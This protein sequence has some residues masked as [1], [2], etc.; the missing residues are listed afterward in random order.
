NQDGVFGAQ[1][2]GAGMGGCAMIL[3]DKKKRDTIKN[4]IN[5]NYVKYFKKKCSIS[6]CQPVNGL[7]IYSSI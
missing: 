2:S 5:D 4:L 6:F 7:S 3:V 1:L